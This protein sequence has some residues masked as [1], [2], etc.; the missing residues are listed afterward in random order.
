MPHLD[1]GSCR[2]Q[3]LDYL[4]ALRPMPNGMTG[5]DSLDFV[6]YLTISQTPKRPTSK[7]RLAVLID[8]SL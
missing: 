8:Q 4:P 3:A 5:A 7:E 6:L 2:R 1:Q